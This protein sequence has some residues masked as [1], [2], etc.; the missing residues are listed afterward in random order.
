MMGMHKAKVAFLTIYPE[1]EI[2]PLMEAA[3]PELFVYHVDNRLP[4]EEKI[5]QTRDADFIIPLPGDISVDLVRACRNLKLVQ[6]LSAGYDRIDVKTI[7]SLGIPVASNGGSNATGVAEF[8]VM[9]MLTVYKCFPPIAK[10]MAEG[11]WARSLWRSSH[12]LEGKTVGIVGLGN[13]GRKV[14]ARL[15]GFDVK[16]IGYDIFDIPERTVKDLGIRMATFE[17]LLGESDIVTLHI[18]LTPETRSFVGKKE[19]ARM[20]SS[21]ILINTSRGAVV[22]ETALYEALRDKIIAGAGLDVLQQEPMA[23]DNPLK[24]IANVIITPHVASFTLDSF[25]RCAHFA[26]GNMRRVLQGEE[27]LAVIK[28]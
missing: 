19:L 5:P 18:P 9:L 20:K 26:Y 28:P 17:E 21:A 3:P 16:L 6:L 11:K 7:S 27:P 8:A 25:L 4:T 22:D 1:D 14:A 10:S 15:R 24:G 12:D 2:K 13:I 23:P